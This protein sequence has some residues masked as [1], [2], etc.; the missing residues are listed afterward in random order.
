VFG[1]GRAPGADDRIAD[2]LGDFAP[3]GDC[4]VKQRVGILGRGGQTRRLLERGR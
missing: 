1:D 2:P 3:A 4:V